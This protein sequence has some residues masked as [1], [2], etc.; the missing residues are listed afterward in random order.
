MKNINKF[1]LMLFTVFAFTSCETDLEKSTALE[2]PVAPVLNAHNAIVVD[3][4]NL[5]TTTVFHWQAAD[6]GYSAATEYSLYAQV[7]EAEKA[8]VTSAYGDSLVIKLED[9]NR[10]VIAAGG[11]ADVENT[12][13]FTLQATISSAY[14]N[15]TSAPITVKITAFKAKPIFLYIAGTANGWT[16]NELCALKAVLPADD[17]EGMVDLQPAEGSLE[18]K[19]CT[20][21]N[22]DGPNYGGSKDALNP[23]GGDI[24]D[25]A[26]GYYRLVVNNAKTKITTALKIETIGV[27]GDGVPGNWGPETKLTYNKATNTWSIDNIEMTNGK[28]YLFR[29]NDSWDYKIGAKPG[30]QPEDYAFGGDNIKVTVPSGNYKLI[31]D[32]NAL[33]YTVELIPIN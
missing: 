24:K 27:I 22:W 29:I 13:T 28:E 18:F 8:L 4:E 25:L 15:V 6:F 5:S 17:F 23:D 16:Q 32:A 21:P 2:N 19:F 26:A 30:G 12:V 1:L 33:P 20:Q 7:G 9:L 10:A 11:K 14:A 3:A 31:L